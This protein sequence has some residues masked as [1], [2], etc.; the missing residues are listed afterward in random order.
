MRPLRGKMRIAIA[1]GSSY[2]SGYIDEVRRLAT[3]DVVFLGSV[4]RDAMRELFSNCYAY[5]LPSVMEGLSVSLLEALSYGCCIVVTDIAENIEV[6]GD[7]ALVFPV[8]DVAALRAR[9][10]SIIDDP[11]LAAQYR[12]RA[13]QRASTQPDWDEV[14]RRTEAFY[15]ETVTGKARVL[16]TTER[17]AAD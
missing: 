6:V 2:S 8:G 4:D 1:G 5:V 14:A 11:D 17:R 16:E 7:A 15:Y 3:D 13:A 9:L 10:S 12:A